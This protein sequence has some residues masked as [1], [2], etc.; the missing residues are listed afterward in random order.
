VLGIGPLKPA[1]ELEPDGGPELEPLCVLEPM[2]G[3]GPLPLLP[4]LLAGAGAVG[5]VE[6]EGVVEVV[7]GAV[8]VAA[9]V[10]VAVALVSADAPAMPAAAPPEANAPATIVAP[11]IREMRM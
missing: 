11:S 2:L 10:V 8:L 7:E 4:D 3:Q 1:P 5:V 9:A 6:V